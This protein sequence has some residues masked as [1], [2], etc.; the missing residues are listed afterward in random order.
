MHACPK[1]WGDVKAHRG[2]YNALSAIYQGV[3]DEVRSRRKHNQKVFLTGHSLGG[4]LV[5]LCAYRFQK[6]GGVPVA[7]VYVFGSP[8]VGDIGF[9]GQFDDL[10]KHKTFRWVRNLDFAS[11]LPVSAGPPLPTTMYHHVGELNF[12]SQ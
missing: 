1:D 5:T 11:K 9:L 4:A 10:L 7:G 3:R 6:V 2:F 12:I 8:R